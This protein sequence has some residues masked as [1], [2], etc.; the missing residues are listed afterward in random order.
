MRKYFKIAVLLLMMVAFSTIA[1]AEKITV[2]HEVSQVQQ[3]DKIVTSNFKHDN[4]LSSKKI[5]DKADP[6]NMD[7]RGIV[8]D[9]MIKYKPFKDGEGDLKSQK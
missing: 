6:V 3:Q 9:R 7:S 4:R 1:L 8:N 5:K 2:R